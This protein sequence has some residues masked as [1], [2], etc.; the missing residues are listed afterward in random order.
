MMKPKGYED[1]YEVV[2]SH[3]DNATIDNQFP[4][5]TKSGENLSSSRLFEIISIDKRTF[6]EAIFYCSFAGANNQR[7]G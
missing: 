7:K 5:K 4:V 2:Y 6:G 1:P 3:A